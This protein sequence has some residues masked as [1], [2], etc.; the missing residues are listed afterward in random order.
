MAWNILVDLLALP[1]QFLQIELKNKAQ[2]PTTKK[3]QFMTS[4][5]PDPY[6]STSHRRRGTRRFK[7]TVTYLPCTG[8]WQGISR[9]SWVSIGSVTKA[10]VANASGSNGSQNCPW[11]PTA[12]VKLWSNSTERQN[13]ENIYAHLFSNWNFN[14][15]LFLLPHMIHPLLSEVLQWLNIQ[16]A[17]PPATRRTGLPKCGCTCPTNLNCDCHPLHCWIFLV[18]L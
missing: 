8:S 3:S 13:L 18:P 9:V 6:T 17:D 11:F 2:V 16:T 5:V 4:K 10:H 14:T 12:M 15:W 1:G 7:K